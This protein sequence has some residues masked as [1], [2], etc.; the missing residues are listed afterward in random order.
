MTMK[1]FIDG[2][3]EIK[4]RKVLGCVKSIGPTKKVTSKKGKISDLTEVIIFD[5]TTDIVLKLWG[6]YYLS[7][8]EWIPSKTILL[9]SNPTFRLEYRGGCSL[10]V[11]HATM[12]DLDPEFPD[13]GWLRKYAASLNKKESVDQTFPNDLWDVGRDI[14]LAM[15]DD[16][17]IL[18]TIADV[19]EW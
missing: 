12:V 5:E 4:D 16:K 15:L 7:A 19:D 13:A 1:S 8:K 3:Y 11:A 6:S 18:F 17:R 14:D 10:G 2:G 9:F